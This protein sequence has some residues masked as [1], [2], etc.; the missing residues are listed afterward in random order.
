MT[1]Q[2]PARRLRPALLVPLVLVLIVAVAVGG[3]FGVRAAAGAPAGEPQ[4]VELAGAEIS[5]DLAGATVLAV[6]EATHGTHEFRV[7][8][9]L[10]AQKVVDRGFTTIAMEENAGRVSQV[11]AWVQ[12][13]PGTAEEAVGRFGFRISRIREMV[14]LLTWAR[15]YNAGRPVGERVRFYGLDMQ[16][17]GADRDVALAWLATVAPDAAASLA[18]GLAAITDDSAHEQALADSQAPAARD[19]LAAVETA[20]AARADDDALRALLSA[21]A[22]VQALERGSQGYRGF[23]RDAALADNLGLVVERRA[24]AGG[25]HT[26]LLAHN[27][28]V[29]RSGQ[30]SLAPGSR[31][32]VLAAERWGDAYRAIGTDARVTR[33]ADGGAVHEFTVDSPVRGLFAGT[34]IGYLEVAQ[35][36]AANREVLDRSMP[37]A[38]A[39]SPF[40]AIHAWLPFSHEVWV[41]PSQTWDALIF[42]ADSTPVTPLP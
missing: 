33:L 24:G 15:A 10:V 41:T 28:H 8:W 20:S 32:G 23:D 3:W 29:D 35:A 21:R 6:G 19:L 26:L 36:S 9:R 40:E 22:L 5:D 12:G 42:V 31:L 14:D 18:P 2:R 4:A 16:R 38:S 7:A 37:M 17:P 25:R 39:G 1:Q 27:G 30:A 11:D 34:R 13:G